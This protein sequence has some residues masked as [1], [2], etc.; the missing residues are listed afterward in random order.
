MQILAIFFITTEGNTRVAL[1]C[2]KSSSCTS[3]R[4]LC[5]ARTAFT[6]LFLFGALLLVAAFLFGAAE[7]ALFLA[8]LGC[9][10]VACNGGAVGGCR[11]NGLGSVPQVGTEVGKLFFNVG[12]LLLHRCAVLAVLVQCKVSEVHGLVY[13]A[14][15]AVFH[16]V[17]VY[18][19]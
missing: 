11:Y 19:H 18:S 7:E 9:R 6:A 1:C 8:L 14:V 2:Y 17:V 3:Y 12:L 16:E 15:V 10:G 5:T 4:Y 13:L